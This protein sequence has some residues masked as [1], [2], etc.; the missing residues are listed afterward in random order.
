VLSDSEIKEKV[1]EMGDEILTSTAHLYPEYGAISILEA[2]KLNAVGYTKLGKAKPAV[3]LIEV[4]LAAN[5]NYN[6]VVRPY[7]D[8]INK[9]EKLIS[10]DQLIEKIHET[11]KEEF[12]LFWGHNDDKKYTVLVEIVKRIPTLRIKYPKA[13]DDY[14]LMNNWANDV[15]LKNYHKD[16]IGEIKFIAIAT[17][18]HLRMSYGCDTVKP[19]QRVK[20][21]LQRRLGFPNLSDLKVIEAVERIAEITGLSALVIDQI[22]VNYGSGYF[23]ISK[24]GLSVVD[25]A[26]SLKEQGVSDDIIIKATQLSRSIVRNL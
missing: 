14:N 7:I 4:V 15:D 17:L 19:D 24:K 12:Y 22:F 21:V 1:F 11:S 5:R 25:I 16:I 20:E 6:K 3:K 23:N 9:D 13:F 8:R 2:S 18:Q 26:K 10:F